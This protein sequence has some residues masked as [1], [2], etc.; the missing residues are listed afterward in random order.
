MVGDE[1][2]SSSGKVRKANRHKKLLCISKT[3][4][5]LTHVPF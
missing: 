3:N 4:L 2:Q 1:M 5:A